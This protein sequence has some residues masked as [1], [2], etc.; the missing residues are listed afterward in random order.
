MRSP[1]IG[2]FIGILAVFTLEQSAARRTRGLA[3]LPVPTSET[4]PY[5]AEVM[6]AASY[7]E[8]VED[9]VRSNV[10]RVQRKLTDPGQIDK[11]LDPEQQEFTEY[12][13][14]MG[15]P[16]VDFPVL[17]SIPRTDFSCRKV[18]SSGYYADLQTGCQVFHIC[19]GGRKISF[20]CPNGTIFRQSHL[21]CDWWFRVDCERSEELYEESAE[22]LAHDQMIYKKRAEEIAKAMAS[23]S[24][25]VSTTER[26]S[27]FR[28]NRRKQKTQNFNSFNNEDNQGQ[29][30]SPQ[31]S[32]NQEQTYNNNQRNF[33]NN[34]LQQEKERQVLAE[35]ASFA[36]NRHRFGNQFNQNYY[37]NQNNRFQS[38]TQPPVKSQPGHGNFSPQRQKADATPVQSNLNRGNFNY[39]SFNNFEQKQFQS[40][41]QP[42]HQTQAHQNNYN[43]NQY[44]SSKLPQYQTPPITQYQTTA[45]PHYQTTTTPQYQSTATPQYQT[46]ATPQYRTTATPR[47]QTTTTP[48]YQS[49]ANSQYHQDFRQQNYFNANHQFPPSEKQT[50]KTQE[51]QLAQHRFH[52]NAQTET[53]SNVGVNSYS[54]SQQTSQSTTESLLVHSQSISEFNNLQ[55]TNR[56]NVSTASQPV[57]NVKVK[58]NKE[59][60]FVELHRQNE[61]SSTLTP[62]EITTLPPYSLTPSTYSPTV[63]HSSTQFAYIPNR[64]TPSSTTH[65]YATFNN[66]GTPEE[67]RPEVVNSLIE[68][69]VTPTSAKALH[70]LASYIG[71]EEVNDAFDGK[72]RKPQVSD[73]VLNFRSGSTEP[74]TRLNSTEKDLPSVLTKQTKDSYEY[75]FSDSKEQ[76][77]KKK[78]D[79]TVK[80][81]GSIFGEN[82]VTTEATSTESQEVE[83]SS[84][85]L[86]LRDSSELRELAQVFSRALSAYLEDPDTFKEI[87]AQVR[88]TEP[89][90]SDNTTP[91]P[92][93]EVLDFSDGNENRVGTT[94]P[95]TT[96]TF[97]ESDGLNFGE[98][99]N[100]ATNR[101]FEDNSL[102]ISSPQPSDI[103][104]TVSTP[105][106]STDYNNKLGSAED[107]SYFPTAGGVSDTTRPRYGGFHNNTQNSKHYSPYG[108]DLPKNITG[109]PL[110][111]T[112]TPLPVTAFGAKL[113]NIPEPQS[114]NSLAYNLYTAGFTS[115]GEDTYEANNSG[116]EKVLI[117]SGS[118]SLVS[119][120]NYSKFAQNFNKQNGYKDM[121]DSDVKNEE[122]LPYFGQEPPFETL[123][124]PAAF[125]TQSP[126]VENQTEYFS[127][128]T[129]DS[130]YKV[131][132]KDV[133][134]GNGVTLEKDITVTTVD[135]ST[136]YT[137]V[138]STTR[139]DSTTATYTPTTYH[140]HPEPTFEPTATT[141]ETAEAF[142]TMK[143]DHPEYNNYMESKAKE[144]FGMLN[145]TAAGALMEMMNKAESNITI[146]RLVLLLVSD[147]SRENKTA[148]ESRHSLINALLTETATDTT[149]PLP[150]TTTLL[151]STTTPKRKTSKTRGNTR[152]GKSYRGTDTYTGNHGVSVELNNQLDTAK[153]YIPM[154]TRS[155]TE[156]K[157]PY[158][159]DARAVEL[160]KTLYNLAAK[161]G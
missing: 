153:L 92:D 122:Y 31:A 24:D 80:E 12:Q 18:K 35:S 91:S 143:P 5:V 137:N 111:I 53:Q 131:S 126:Y 152:T 107:Q 98:I 121:A 49:S 60:S 89:N 14:V 16:G 72:S 39:N 146:R 66:S 130:E 26:V 151:P 42:Q 78:D 47:Y 50:Y 77:D 106:N 86:K 140:P 17:P 100:L 134:L 64:T 62:L 76:T 108:S 45:T 65:Q 102:E 34:Q 41:D 9:D 136:T 25:D 37:Q 105:E 142:T 27:N 87:L 115:S 117:T 127:S 6:G 51:N 116:E 82:H 97:A 33:Q 7:E 99:N 94:E 44:Q 95:P 23:K 93:D 114:V 103:H 2:V 56:P 43:Q 21:I 133:N 85:N 3:R 67:I 88:P 104:T 145:E 123:G 129:K 38:T 128:S 157:L 81:S 54:T 84:E 109:T 19:D 74:P 141:Q 69:G 4:I 139:F 96:T 132:F 22:Q 59:F 154:T 10:K 29:N 159:S 110:S 20:L 161:W 32:F 124:Q 40:P 83:E 147:K 58:S 63:P 57:F 55:P 135:S 36:S 158:D 68:T 138:D 149:T 120:D 61:P 160:L 113:T 112:T 119:S 1:P 118:Q 75:L 155:T 48:Q 8:T 52:I 156:G 101:H 46:T 144:M 28:P 71:S 148:A 79:L 150:P 90:L 125:Q 15:R 11:D 30:Y 13:G 70:S 73:V